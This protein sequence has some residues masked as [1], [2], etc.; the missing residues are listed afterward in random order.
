MSPCNTELPVGD[1]PDHPF[2]S[3]TNA[4]VTD[5]PTS[6]SETFSYLIEVYV[7]DFIGI[8]I[9]ASLETRAIKPCGECGHV[10][11]T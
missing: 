6:S 10:W 11:H 2:V 4:H 1:L 3:H 8:A 5:L 9:P 7:D